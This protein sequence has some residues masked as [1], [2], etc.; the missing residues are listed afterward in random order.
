MKQK[1]TLC[2]PQFIVLFFALFAS[3][4]CLYCLNASVPVFVSSIGGGAT[5]SGVLNTCFAL[6]ACIARL[7]GGHCADRFGRKRVILAGALFIAAG[8]AG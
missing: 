6:S 1:Q 7:A 8:T 2:H 4:Y 3:G 5:A